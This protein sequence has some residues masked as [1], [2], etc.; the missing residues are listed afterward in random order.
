MIGQGANDITAQADYASSSDLSS[1]D[2]GKLAS[3]RSAL[4]DNLLMK[5]ESIKEEDVNFAT[6]LDKSKVFQKNEKQIKVKSLSE[7][8]SVLAVLTAIY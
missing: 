5:E 3:S 7:N 1:K 8:T 2:L 4:E 6:V